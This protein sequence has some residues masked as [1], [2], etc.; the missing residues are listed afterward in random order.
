VRRRAH[1]TWTAA[2]DRLNLIE[3]HWG[4]LLAAPLVAHPIE[5]NSRRSITTESRLRDDCPTA[6][7]L[8]ADERYPASR[9]C[10][11]FD[12]D[13]WTRPATEHADFTP[14]VADRRSASD[15]SFDC[16][17]DARP[18]AARH[19]HP[20]VFQQK[21]KTRRRFLIVP[22]KAYNIGTGR[23]PQATGEAGAAP[24]LDKIHKI[25]GWAQT[26]KRLWGSR[27]AKKPL[28]A[29]LLACAPLSI[30]HVLTGSLADRIDILR[31]AHWGG[32]S[33]Q[34][35][36]SR[37]VF[38][39]LARRPLD[40]NATGLGTSST[41]MIFGCSLFLGC[42][43]IWSVCGADTGLLREARLV[44]WGTPDWCPFN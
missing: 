38:H 33:V 13:Q 36:L 39:W 35:F 30:T 41:G 16:V 32:I 14:A 4:C 22:I 24:L 17:P 44:F 19:P 28:K 11:S 43:S 1:E 5:A 29:P 31:L 26:I 18:T 20:A 27:S 7:L 23:G 10:W 40:M 2:G 25:T 42:S 3:N 15:G 21:G 37:S 6:L 12:G 8:L 9:H 34:E